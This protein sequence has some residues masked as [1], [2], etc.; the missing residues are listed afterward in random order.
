MARWM[1]VGVGLCLAAGVALGARST[2][3]VDPARREARAA[4]TAYAEVSGRHQV[5]STRTQEEAFTGATLSH[6]RTAASL[7]VHWA[8]LLTDIKTYLRLG[9]ILPRASEAQSGQYFAADRRVEGDC[10]LA[11]RSIGDL[12]P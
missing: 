5:A 11:G 6:S 2:H 4:C 10:S 7:D 8:P 1:L 3:H 9:R 12:E